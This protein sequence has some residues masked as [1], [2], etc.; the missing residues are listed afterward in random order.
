MLLTLFC[1]LTLCM[2]QACTH[3]MSYY[4]IGHS[5]QPDVLRGP[6]T[7]E[8]MN[9]CKNLGN[10]CRCDWQY[11]VYIS[12]GGKQKFI[13]ITVNDLNGYITTIW[14]TP[15]YILESSDEIWHTAPL[16]SKNAPLNHFAL[17]LKLQQ[18]WQRERGFQ[19]NLP[20][21]D[22]KFRWPVA[23]EIANTLHILRRE[24]DA[25]KWITQHGP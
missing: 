1:C 2:H 18:G 5:C 4:V 13:N 24:Q 7:Q 6:L 12:L 19:L 3:R 25:L 16:L 11:S 20:N 14:V 17:G 15:S 9:G 10:F 23:G 22:G 21:G 8:E